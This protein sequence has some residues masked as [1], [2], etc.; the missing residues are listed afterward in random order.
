MWSM[1]SPDAPRVTLAHRLSDYPEL[2]FAAGYSGEPHHGVMDTWRLG[3]G[4]PKKAAPAKPSPMI[5]PRSGSAYPMNRASI[6]A[7]LEVCIHFNHF[8]DE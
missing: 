5:R 2:E 4:G 6:D 8:V 3:L 7:Q 1:I